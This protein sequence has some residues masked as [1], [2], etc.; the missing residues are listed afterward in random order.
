MLSVN[1]PG[2]RDTTSS[3]GSIA[4][5]LTGFAADPGN[6]LGLKVSDETISVST[7]P[8]TV[9]MTNLG[10]GTVT[11]KY[12]SGANGVVTNPGEPAVPL[13]VH[14]VSV[15]GQVLRGVGFRGGTYAEETLIPLT[16]APADPEQQIRG[17]H[18]GFASPVFFPMRLATPNYFDA[19]SGGETNLLITP[20]QHRGTGA[21]DGTA[22]L[23][24]YTGLNLH[25]FY[26]SYTGAAAASG[27][28]TITNVAAT[29]AGS[30]VTFSA[31]AFGDPRAG[32]QQVWVTYT[33]H[34]NAWVSVDLE[35]SSTDSTLWTKTI[36]LPAA[37]AGRSIDFLVQ[38]VNGVGL[39]SLDDNL[40]R[41]YSVLGAG[42]TATQTITIAAPSIKTLGDPDFAVSAAASSGLPVTLSAAGSCTVS[43][44]T[45][46]ITAIGTCT[47]TGTQAGNG[48]YGPA[49]ATATINVRWPF[50][51]FFS[52][53]DNDG[54]INSAKAGSTIPVKF[55][56]GG[57]RGLALFQATYP[58][59]AKVACPAGSTVEPVEE[60]TTATSAL[61]YDAT[62]NQYQYNWKTPKTYAGSCYRLD[63]RFVDG[64]TQSALF[65]FN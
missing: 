12:Y 53:I 58:K 37:S 19:L 7:T 48:T 60:T 34:A 14:N 52:P 49:T 65:K 63:V 29:V 9:P 18:R 16:G 26:S 47:L 3:P 38:A 1:M 8:H 50:T 13:Q 61:T 11:A 31:R 51:G 28:P 25:L 20:A 41:T 24:R 17:I 33:G 43:G 64:S 23:R 56:L 21:N 5:P 44:T 46:H 42:Q 40:G 36:P 2:S 10:G 6:E 62:K 45:V 32:I 55:S 15:S 54:V 30:N 39:V 27:A 57:N 59:A 22:I 4:G 35:Q